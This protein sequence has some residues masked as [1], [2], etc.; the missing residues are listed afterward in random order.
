MDFSKF[1]SEKRIAV[2]TPENVVNGVGECYFGTF[3]SEFKNM[4]FLKANR[5]SALPNFLNKA[6]LTLWEACEIDFDKVTLLTAVC[7]MA[8]FGTALTVLYDK[9]TKKCTYWQE[10]LFP[11]SKA[12][13]SKNLLS[14]NETYSKAKNVKIRFVND[15][16]KGEA[17][18][19]GSANSKKDGLIDYRVQ[20]NRVSK[21]SVV[22]IPF[23]DNRPL[24]SQKDLFSVNGY[25]SYNG[26]TFHATSASAAI[27]D[28]HRGYYPRKS[29]YD[30]VTTMGK[31]EIDG[32]QQYFGFNLTRNQSIDQDKFNE[33]LIWFEGDTTLL[34]PVVFR[35]ESDKLWHVQDE[36]GMVDLTF[37]IGDE[38]LM[39]LNAGVIRIDYHITFGSL[40][41][42][43][44]DPKGEKYI[45]DGMVGIGE[46][47]SLVF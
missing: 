7:D 35:H 25:I 5:P 20:L 21:P 2:P 24:Y 29:H 41:G 42:Y 4:D 37:D 8:L 9:R 26:E 1:L 27:I 10:M 47:K 30:W 17:I 19:S 39:K 36:H 32:K 11:A 33:N 34:T 28:D 44:C 45:L 40:S 43:V 23:G 22:S 46:D 6:R 15:F 12:V 31:R 38:F 3:R 18:V 14:G 16:Q 13:I